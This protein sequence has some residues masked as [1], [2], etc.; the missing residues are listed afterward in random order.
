MNNKV[1][2]VLEKRKIIANM[3]NYYWNQIHIND[4]I[5]DID[6]DYS[7]SDD[8]TYYTEN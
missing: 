4:E 2:N 3:V 5:K 7:D 6:T 1:T 8:D